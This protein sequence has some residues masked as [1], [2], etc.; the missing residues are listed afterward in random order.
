MRHSATEE[1][2]S[3]TDTLS[4]A[5]LRAKE[6]VPLMLANFPGVGYESAPRRFRET[7]STI[8]D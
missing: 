5:L 7:R 1:E 3:T 6:G 2:G 8:L 4:V